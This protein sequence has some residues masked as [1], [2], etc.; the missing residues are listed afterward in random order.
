MS[1]TFNSVPSNAAASKVFVEQEA[2]NRGTGS[3][4]IPHKKLVMGHYNSGKSP[5]ANVA[6]LILSLAD[7]WDRYGRGSQ[8][9]A[10]IEKAGV[11]DGVPVYAIPLAPDGSGV[12]AVGS[13]AFSG[14]ATAAGTL[15][16]YIAGRRVT[17]AVA[18]GDTAAE[19]ATAVA[20]AVNADLDLPVTASADT[21]TVTVTSRW[22]GE[23]SNQISLQMNRR[24]TDV[25]PAGLSVTVTDVGSG[26]AG[27]EDPDVSTALAGLGDTWFTEIAFP[28][29]SADALTALKA[30]GVTR[31]DP[32]VNRPFWAFAGYTGTRS[33]FIT[34]LGNHNSEWLTFVP[35]HG[36]PS[37]A[38]EIA[39]SAAKL[40]AQV[41]QNTPGRPL[42]NQILP[43]VSAGDTNDQTYAENDATVKAG[44][45]T[46]E[47]TEGGGV[48]VIDLVTTRITTDAGADTDA[49]RFAEIIPNIQFKRYALEQVFKAS[50]YDQAVVISDDDLPGPSYAIRPRAAKSRCIQLVD[51]WVS[52]GMST[53]RDE[54]V[55]GITAEINGDNAGRIDVLIPD[56]PSAGLR[57]LAAKLE[58]DFLV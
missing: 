9:A 39:A 2:V 11:Q 36:S 16:I 55:A 8:L 3:P 51:D 30:A 58:W 43:G 38:Y 34:E 25:T 44:G 21:G 5:T 53:S 13:L 31:D 15:A 57:I 7:A 20:A 40:A 22:A 14:T 56:V 47:N 48:K 10:M 42:K 29:L 50:P 17:V 18:V 26:T 23:S 37:P 35:V 54:I 33:A 1:I 46:T 4:L 45:S 6:Q 24:D 52:R 12:A 28:F 49:W 19:V 27:E 32:G 41:Q